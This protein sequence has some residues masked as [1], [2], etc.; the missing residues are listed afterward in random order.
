M[1]WWGV[2]VLTLASAAPAAVYKCTNGDG[3]VS[4]QASL[5]PAGNAA[6]E[7]QP[8]AS[9]RAP[10]KIIDIDADE[11]NRLIKESVEAE[12][13]LRKVSDSAVVDMQDRLRQFD[14]I[15]KI[16]ESTPRVSLPNVILRLSDARG[17]LMQI[18]F[19]GCYNGP[20]D[21]LGAHMSDVIDRLTLFMSRAEIASA[22]KDLFSLYSR[23]RYQ[24]A[25]ADCAHRSRAEGVDR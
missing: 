15:R 16:A 2:V 23:M 21:A 22:Q 6:A 14:D 17:A 5:C 4:Y 25:L 1:R 19:S 24:I 20:R 12:S 10:P 18:G 13:Y 7:I 9:G 8:S 11:K 3:S